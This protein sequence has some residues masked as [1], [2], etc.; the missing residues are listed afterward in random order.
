M[1][2]GLAVFFFL[3]RISVKIN[4]NIEIINEQVVV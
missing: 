4:G 2:V 3:F 1:T